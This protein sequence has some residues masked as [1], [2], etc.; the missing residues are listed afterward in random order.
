MEGGKEGRR[1]KIVY[2]T[3]CLTTK[4]KNSAT[5]HGLHFPTD[6]IVR[7]L[8]HQLWNTSWKEKQLNRSFHQDGSL[9]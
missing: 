2:V 3:Y 1:D 8:F 7:L 4:A 9:G 6:M 5:L